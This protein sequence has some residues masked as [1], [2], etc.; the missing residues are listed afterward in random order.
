[1]TKYVNLNAM[2]KTIHRH[3]AFFILLFVISALLLYFSYYNEFCEGAADNIWHYYFSKYAL[4]Y[5][6][7]F[8]HH[9]GKPIFIIL[10]T[11]FAQFGFYGMKVFNIICAITT[12]IYI[13]K[14]LV[15][16][17]IYSAWASVVVIFFT[18]LYFIVVQSALTEPL[19]ALILT[20]CIYYYLTDKDITASIIL[21]FILFSRS[22]GMFILA[23]FAV[24]LIII[25]KWKV[26][27]FLFLGFIIYSFVG[28]FMGHDFFWYFT[29]N[30]YSLNSPYGHGHYT[31]IL[32][33]YND[34]WGL[35]FLITLCV[36][37]VT[38]FYYF[39]KEKQYLFWKSQNETSKIMYLVFVPSSVFLVFHL[40]VWHYGLCGSA[41]LERVL[42]CVLPCNVILIFWAINKIFLPKISNIFVVILLFF[43][44][45]TPFK[46]FSYPLKAW[47][48][49]RCELEAAEW[50]KTI[51]PEKCI[52]YYAYPN[53][54]FNLNKDPFDK[55]LN[56]EQ[57][58]YNK[59]CSENE[60]LPTFF[61]WDSAFSVSSCGVKIEDV[62]KCNYKQ[63]K[64]FTDGGNFRL[65][66]FEKI[67]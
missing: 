35:P 42:A 65:I 52:I 46:T 67:K 6:D 9:W 38:L 11:W 29:E 5:P 54:I 51:M 14:I 63:I 33:R 26:L 48:A 57:F 64:E 53:I 18:P 62:E 37:T 60:T 3:I 59:D 1:V 17:N 10:S 28:Y 31:D 40:Y 25:K 66:V 50:F 23:C 24:Y 41:G 15:H 13:Y 32:K 19:F 16:L 56:R 58:A 44:V 22:E 36:S 21:S 2:L 12:A 55:Y 30:P 39:L 61:F 34:I 49:D 43:H 8:L 45:Q 20:C 4:T 7:F 47:G 27:P